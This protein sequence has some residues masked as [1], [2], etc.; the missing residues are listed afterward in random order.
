[1]AA[2]GAGLGVCR[3]DSEPIFTA[4]GAALGLRCSVS[5]RSADLARL[6]QGFRLGPAL[7][8]RR[9]HVRV[10]TGGQA[11]GRLKQRVSCSEGTRSIG[12]RRFAPQPAPNHSSYTPVEG[13]ATARGGG[14]GAAWGAECLVE[15]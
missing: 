1:M 5:T 7:F 4:G 8:G 12:A 11:A 6:H 9:R 2:G 13:V 10:G 14:S 15:R 3:R